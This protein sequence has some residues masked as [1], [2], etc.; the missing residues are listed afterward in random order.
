MDDEQGPGAVNHYPG[1]MS[2]DG[3]DETALPAQEWRAI[4]PSTLQGVE[5]PERRWIVPQWLPKR[6]VTLNYA[7]GGIGKTLLAMQLMAATAL[8]KPWCGLEV[9]PCVSLGLFSEDDRD[10][11]H[12]RLNGI[13]HFYGA[14]FSDMDDM[15]LVDG[16]GQDNILVVW[17]GQR[18][19]PTPRLEQLREHALDIGAKLVVIDTA[20]TTFG[21]NEND[22]AQVTSYVGTYLTRLAQDID[23]AVLLNAHPSLS[24]MASGS[25]TSGSTAWNNSCRSRWALVRPDGEDGKPKLDSM[26]RVLTRRKSNAAAAGETLSIEWRDGVFAVKATPGGSASG[27]RKDAAEQAFMAGLLAASRPLSDSKNA[28]NFAP[29]IIHTTPQG[30][31]FTTA[32]LTEALRNLMSRGEIVVSEYEQNYRTFYQIRP[33][34]GGSK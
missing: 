10:E 15:T 9:E 14:S 11:L 26:E 32:E 22:R 30:R 21:G 33:A 29:K 12:I 31:D 8:S 19:A 5:V 16:T 28:G 17:D 7:D 24:G 23:G 34:K 2:F 20:A 25:Q 18:L 3:F 4:R 6:Q 13:R 1:Q 27:T